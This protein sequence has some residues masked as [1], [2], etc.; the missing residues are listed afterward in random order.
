MKKTA[1]AAHFG[2]S[3]DQ[4]RYAVDQV[5]EQFVV[6]LRQEVAD[7]VGT[8]ADIDAEIRELESLL[9]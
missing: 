1:L 7:Q 3:R 5:N 9:D 8:S 4:V 2:L 6:L